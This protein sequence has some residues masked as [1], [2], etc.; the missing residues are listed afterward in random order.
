M[1]IPK[2]AAYT[3]GDNTRVVSSTAETVTLGFGVAVDD[4]YAA[5]A[6]KNGI[7]GAWD[8]ADADGIYN[9]FRYVFDKPRGKFTI[10]DISF[11]SDGNVVVTTAKVVNSEGFTISVIETSDVAGE[12]VTDEREITSSSNTA[13]F[14]K[15]EPQRF[16][17]LK[18]EPSKP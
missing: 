15:S 12:N 13:T 5:W 3:L 16:Y 8:E 17:R 2:S 6:A 18:A 1:T 11:D 7:T 10:I 9:V 14:E 4:S